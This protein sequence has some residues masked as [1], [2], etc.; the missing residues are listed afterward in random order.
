M[1]E[2]FNAISLSYIQWL[3]S[4]K[5]LFIIGIYKKVQNHVKK[6][7]SSHNSIISTVQLTM[8]ISMRI[9]VY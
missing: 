5:V 9:T 1:N 6:L 3:D 2:L 4:F 7:E 8:D